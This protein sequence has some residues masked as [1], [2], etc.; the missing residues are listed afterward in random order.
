MAPD[1]ADSAL[2][3]LLALHKLLVEIELIK[4]HELAVGEFLADY[5]EDHGLVVERHVV[6][7]SPHREN[8]YAHAGVR[9]TTVLLTLHIDT[10][11]PYIPYRREGDRIFGRGS[12]DAKALVATMVHTYLE[13]AP[14]LSPQDLALLFVVGEETGGDGMQE[15]HAHLNATWE[16]VVFGEPTELKLGVGHK[17][18]YLFDIVAKGKAA[19]SGYPQLGVNA[20][21]QL[22]KVL[23]QLIDTEW[24][25]DELLG[26]LTFN[27]GH[28]QGGLAAN[29][30]PADASALCS[31]RVASN[32]PE[33]KRLVDVAAAS[34]PNTTVVFH[35]EAEE[36]HLDFDV[37]G[38]DT[39][40]LGY[41]TDVPNLPGPFKRYLYG[42]GT[43]TVAHGANEYVD[44]ADLAAAVGGYKRLVHHALK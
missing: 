38:F 17:G 35:A 20:N 7:T 34:Q 9:N 19:H 4:P 2:A 32:L 29:V 27:P 8:I 18:I 16:H 39:I 36:V 33:I 11:P 43:I 41:A 23:N 13:L 1:S 10:V 24:P 44:V 26:P 15:A 31:V 40:V 30:I 6:L 28:I 21:T 5:L 3:P 37:P 42:P 12:C 14:S 22:V 25:A